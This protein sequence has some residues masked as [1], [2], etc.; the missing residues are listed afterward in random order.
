[1][2]DKIL[3]PPPSTIPA[4]SV[5][6][7]LY[8]AEKYVGECLDSL[9]GQTFQDFEVIVVNDCSTDGSVKVVEEYAPKFN[10]RLRLTHTETNSGGCA[11]PRNVG[12]SL[13]CGE[14]VSF[15]DADDAFTKTALE[16]LYTLAKEYDADVVY[17][18]KNYE[19]NTDGSH[20]RIKATAER[21]F[22]DKPTLEPDDLKYRVE[23][24]L[25]GK[26]YN[27]SWVK[28]VQRKL[29]I[30]NKIFFPNIHPSE[31][32]V[33]THGLIFHAKKFLRVPNAVYIYR[34][35]ENSV[36]RTKRTPQ[37]NVN[38]W[39]YPVLLGLKSLDEFIGRCEFFEENPE[40]RYALLKKF[41]D[42]RLS[43]LLSSSVELPADVI[44]R[45]IKEQF[46]EQFGEYDVLI[47][48]LCSYACD[49]NKNL[50]ETQKLQQRIAEL[51][52]SLEEA[53]NNPRINNLPAV[54]VIIPMYNTEEYI[55]ELLESLLIQT[56]QDFEV[57]VVDDCSSDNSFEAA[58]SYLPK[59]GGRLKVTKTEKNSKGA[60]YVPR[61]M[62]LKLSRGE[63]VIFVDSDDFLLGTA[64]ETLYNAAKEYDVD[65]VYFSSYYD[66]KRPNSIY[67]HRDGFGRTLF[68]ADVENQPM[69]IDNRHKI[70]QQLLLQVTGEGNFHHPWSKFVRRDFLIKNEIT[71]PTNMVNG[72][73]YIWCVHVYAYAKRF[74]RLPQAVYFYRNYNTSVTRT[75]RTPAEQIHYLVSTY[76]DFLKTLNKI[77]NKAEFLMENPIYCQKIANSHFKWFLY[78]LST[79]VVKNLNNAEIY[80]LLSYDSDK[81][82]DVVKAAA[83]F[84]FN[85]IEAEQKENLDSA[86]L[87]KLRPYITARLDIQMVLNYTAEEDDFKILCF[88]DRAK[89]K[90][91]TWLPQ[92]NIG[93]TIHSYVGKLELVAKAFSDGQII[94]GL[95][96]LEVRDKT[97]RI[98]YWIDY[99][100]LIVNDK[101]IFDTLK[102]AWHNKPYLYKAEVKA[103]EEIHIQVEW[104]PHRSDTIESKVAAPPP[105]PESKVAAPAPK[106]ESKVRTT[107][108]K[109]GSLMPRKFNP[110]ITARIDAKFTSTKAGD[111]QILSIS[112]DKAKIT[113]PG[114]FQ[115]NGI[116]YI[117]QSSHGELIFIAKATADGQITLNLRGMEIRNPDDWAKGIAK[118][119]P[120]WIDYTKLTVNE[121]NI[122]STRTPAWCDEPYKY[123]MDV[124]ANEEIVVVIKWQPHNDT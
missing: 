65:V 93:Y 82:N 16:E 40:Y 115:N 102:P 122:F 48:Y 106:P 14:Y 36:M 104:Q 98:P 55:G 44:Y 101:L 46:G 83:P 37:E 79:E 8:N 76:V 4:I 27:L 75:I 51:E 99:T 81:E 109:L 54:S 57:I 97:K 5:I 35:S 13:A 85:I 38:F 112:D 33:W 29:M 123:V 63:Y 61:N 89:I 11:V 77:Q 110:L 100:K 58:K 120:Y 111:F 124:K 116:G 92:N 87:L 74:L 56:F 52:N 19:M 18:E 90:K 10:G 53:F 9:L 96:G 21:V 59:F 84:F 17:C 117:I 105:K 2:Y 22:V 28:M 71:Y 24:M 95:K 34:L 3:T 86:L 114:W 73:D 67:L 78:R 12:L 41:V 69:F 7:P 50:Q 49:V 47:S 118:R 1:M 25:E 30:D 121:K 43:W 26:Y 39:L 119:I 23:A 42:K 88:D 80:E 32:A 45:S 31:D 108:Y 113:K 66:M 70:F 62:G 103:G 6:I 94:L 15:M 68:K 107:L 64:L 91:I 72:G 20:I 60:G